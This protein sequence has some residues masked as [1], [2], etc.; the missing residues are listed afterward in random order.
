MYMAF[1]F[2]IGLLIAYLAGAELFGLISLMIVNASIF[3]II[4]GLGTDSS[5]VWHGAKKITSASQL[6]TFTITTAFFQI[7]V[8]IAVSLS[9]FYLTGKTMLAGS[10]DT[11]I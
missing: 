6:M 11:P 2:A 8:F 5:I 9:W 1:N 7:F 4:S 10:V 3:H